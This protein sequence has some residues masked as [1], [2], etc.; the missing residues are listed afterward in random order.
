MRWW[1]RR[2]KMMNHSCS[3][4][5]KRFK[6]KLRLYFEN[7]VNQLPFPDAD[8]KQKAEPQGVELTHD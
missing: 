6:P 7:I 5:I 2:T 4:K 3:R 1:N 8:S